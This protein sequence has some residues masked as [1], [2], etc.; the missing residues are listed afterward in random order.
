[1]DNTQAIKSALVVGGCGSLGHR[2]V[3]GLLKLEP[4]LQICVFDL[5]TT[6]NRF[7]SVEYYE[8]DISVK[9][10]IYS[11]LRKTQPEVIFH[12]ASPPPSL[13]DLP[14]YMNINVEGTRKLLECAKELGTKAF[15]YTSSASV[16]HD[17]VS[18]LVNGDE[19]LPLL[20]LPVQKEI[21]SHTKALA[22]QLVLDT[23]STTK[24]GMLT[25]CIRP[26]SMF[27][28]N[29]GT[30]KAFIDNAAAGKLKYTV[31]TGK[32]MFDFTCQENVVD[33]HILA[34]QALLRS[35]V[36]P[37][38]SDMRVAGEGFLISND[39][40]MPFWDFAR[41]LGDA[42]GYP[43]R[44]EDIRVMPKSVGLAMAVIAEWF[45][46]ITSFGR[47]KSRM[48]RIGIRY[49]CMTRTYRIEKAKRVLGYK[50][51]VSLKEGIRK[52]G[53]FFGKDR[54]SSK[55]LA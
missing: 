49:S 4:P 50:P 16:I 54:K 9:D 44:K 1:M 47:R 55:K 20:Y 33:A 41:A 15:I 29:D 18:D 21:Y 37:P 8:V 35:F 24:G 27:G 43:T 28:A 11:A 34:A 31:G 14:L 19:S 53:E 3:E 30:A 39:E 36:K 6:Q 5:K 40:P 17:S 32:N 13:T 45:V 26:V 51:R 48:N 38:P 23:N 7:P 52:A 25:T 22:D 12:T 10:Q 2:I 46:W 42:A